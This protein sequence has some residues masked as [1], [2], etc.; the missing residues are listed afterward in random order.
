LLLQWLPSHLK[1]DKLILKAGTASRGHQLIK[2]VRATEN[3]ISSSCISR[4]SQRLLESGDAHNGL[5]KPYDRNDLFCFTTR[6]AQLSAR[7]QVALTCVGSQ[8][9]KLT[10]PVGYFAK[11]KS[12]PSTHWTVRPDKRHIL[13]QVVFLHHPLYVKADPRGLE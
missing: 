6:V 13:V 12:Q 8:C 10:F 7:F 11:S 1:G 4:F 3:C 2:P 5:V 9:Y